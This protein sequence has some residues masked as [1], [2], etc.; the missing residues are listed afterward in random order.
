MRIT[1]ETR[2]SRHLLNQ[3]DALNFIRGGSAVFTLLSTK[4]RT[5]YTY[6]V[7]KSFVSESL[8]DVY[9]MTGSDNVRDYGNIGLIDINSAEVKPIRES[10]KTKKQ[11]IAFSHVYLN[12][13]VGINMPNLE[14]WHE[15]MC[16][17]C[18][19]R[20]TVPMSIELGIGPEC[21]SKL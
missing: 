9:Y 6:K 4:T 7:T 18:G 20:L 10:V 14:I 5:R 15:G 13:C 2:K 16:C 3:K 1:Q 21:I 12:L 11:F 8:F 17:R 19:R